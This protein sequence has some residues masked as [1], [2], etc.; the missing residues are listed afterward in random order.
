MVIK[1]VVV[2]QVCGPCRYSEERDDGSLF[3]DT[4]Q[5]TVDPEDDACE[6]ALPITCTCGEVVICGD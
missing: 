3:C 4:K 1:G 6:I 2:R 5:V